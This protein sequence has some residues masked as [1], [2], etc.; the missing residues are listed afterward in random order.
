MPS[1]LEQCSFCTAGPGGP[2]ETRVWPDDG[3]LYLLGSE[4]GKIGIKIPGK[5]HQ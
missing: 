3:V 4:K 1:G 5:Q 2:G